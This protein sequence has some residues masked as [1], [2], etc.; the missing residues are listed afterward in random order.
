M[1]PSPVIVHTQVK[2]SPSM[3]PYEAPTEYVRALLSPCALNF[4]AAAEP[5]AD[6]SALLGAFQPLADQVAGT[7]V[8]CVQGIGEQLS[9]A[10]FA[11]MEA[12]DR[13]LFEFGIEADLVRNLPRIYGDSITERVVQAI[14]KT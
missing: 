10:D 6:G 8:K 14:R 7:W 11:S 5:G 3:T 9:Q 1:P 13:K 4:S 12:R 2:A